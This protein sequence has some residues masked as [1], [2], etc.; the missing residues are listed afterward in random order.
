MP[1]ALF[2]S[3]RYCGVNFISFR[4]LRIK[5]T[6]KNRNVSMVDFVELNCSGK[7]SFT[8]DKKK[9]NCKVCTVKFFEKAVSKCCELEP[10]I[11]F[12]I[13]LKIICSSILC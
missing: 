3:R 7:S 10:N 5:R 12:K 4:N 6:G 11:C 8:S 13:A 2:S 9:C 1:Y